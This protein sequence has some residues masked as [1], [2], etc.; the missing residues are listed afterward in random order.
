MTHC[1]KWTFPYLPWVSHLAD[2]SVP[3]ADIW[4]LILLTNNKS[5]LAKVSS[6]LTCSILCVLKFLQHLFNLLFHSAAVPT[7]LPATVA[8]MS[9]DPPPLPE[10]K[11]F[12]VPARTLIRGQ[13]KKKR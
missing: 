11:V 10:V 2:V 7:L 13:K 5:I 6:Q 12:S 9:G 4:H 3:N 8:N 1:P